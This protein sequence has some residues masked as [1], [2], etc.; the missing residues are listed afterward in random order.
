[1][2]QGATERSNGR[3]GDGRG[4]GRERGRRERGAMGGEEVGTDGSLPLHSASPR[5]PAATQPNPTQPRPR[6]LASSSSSPRL[7][8]PSLGVRYQ[9]AQV[10][11]SSSPARPRARSR[12]P[13]PTTPD[14][15]APLR[16]PRD[17]GPRH[18][19][20]APNPPRRIW[21]LV[22]A[23]FFFEFCR[24]RRRRGGAAACAGAAEF[25]WGVW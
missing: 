23:F 10:V 7:A 4:R 2:G 22:F 11:I 8:A 18:K 12:S 15:E 3:G 21:P 24:L 5:D 14:P 20:S 16:R 25:R 19:V 1:M 9:P 13:A 6:G 17:R